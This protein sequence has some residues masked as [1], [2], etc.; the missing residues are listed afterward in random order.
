MGGYSGTPDRWSSLPNLSKV[1]TSL[2]HFKMRAAVNLLAV[3]E[4]ALGHTCSPVPA[5]GLR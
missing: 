1:F 2:K 4:Q 3:N 5:G